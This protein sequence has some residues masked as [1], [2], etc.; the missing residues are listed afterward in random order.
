MHIV[1]RLA[2]ELRRPKHNELCC[3]VLV[4]MLVITIYSSSDRD[5]S[6]RECIVDIYH[7]RD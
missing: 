5:V 6:W 1:Y 3:D 7:T 4:N 2:T